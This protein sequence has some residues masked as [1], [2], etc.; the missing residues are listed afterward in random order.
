MN[1]ISYYSFN[2]NNLI[3]LSTLNFKDSQ[4]IHK[5]IKLFCPNI[6]MSNLQMKISENIQIQ[7]YYYSE[8][9]VKVQVPELEKKLSNYLK[10]KV[11]ILPIPLKFPYLDSQIYADYIKET[12]TPLKIIRQNLLKVF[13]ENRH[14][15]F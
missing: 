10:R 11:E 15:G 1:K 9:Q 14:P 8:K 7:F 3:H 13:Q 2:N 6:L 12:N 4:R 5:I